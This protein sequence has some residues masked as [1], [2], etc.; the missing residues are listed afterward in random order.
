[1]IPYLNEHRLFNYSDI[2]AKALYDFQIDCI[3]K[4]ISNKNINDMLFA[5]KLLY[6]RLTIQGTI[7]YNPFIGINQV[8]RA[9]SKEKGFFNITDVKGLFNTNW[10]NHETEYMFNLIAFSTGLRNSEIRML[11][12]TDLEFIN[13]IHFINV[14]N[15]RENEKGVKTENAYRKI[16]L[17][18]FVYNKIKAYI[19]K[20][21]RNGLLFVRDN[22]TVYS[23]AEVSMMI[24]VVSQKLEYDKNYLIT[25]NITF[26][27]WRHLFSTI[28]Y[29]NGGIS[30][31]WIECF[32]GHKQKGVKAIYTH[33]HNVD[34]IDACKKLVDIISTSLI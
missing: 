32:M 18:D 1:L 33:L 3:E 24:D 25:N 2:D 22:N 10:E 13:D 7:K 27:S 15:A 28:L 5:V 26:H 23:A 14:T 8:K 6:N 20:Y 30:S 12:T 17:T 21:N 34:G 9:K 4:G 16:P 29:E 31:D 19:K 11:K